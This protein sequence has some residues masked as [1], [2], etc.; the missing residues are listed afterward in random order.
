M[1]SRYSDDLIA[2]GN[3][4]IEQLTSRNRDRE[5]GLSVLPRSDSF[6][7]Q[8]HPGRPPLRLR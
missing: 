6:L 4:A 8:R 7:G 5:E 1:P 3:S 2:I